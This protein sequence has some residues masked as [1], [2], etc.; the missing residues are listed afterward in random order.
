MLQRAHVAAADNVLV[1][2]ASGGVGTA[3][4]QLAK[5]RGARVT[6]VVH[7]SKM[8]ALAMLGADHVIDRDTDVAAALGTVQMDVVVDNVA[9][10]SFAER[11]KLL[12]NGGRFVTSG[13]IGGSQV[14]M[15]LRPVYLRDLSI[16]GC[17]AWEDA[18][19]SNLI[20]YI[21]LGELRPQVAQ[22]FPLKDIA[23]AQR[24]FLKR[25]HI[26]KFVLIPPSPS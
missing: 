15:D 6:A 14:T 13:A 25:A 1:V 9:G 17:T 23:R 7:R 19:F 26:G 10:P 8:A 4:V 18:V 2:G 12:R 20:S 3:T 21:E 11:L 24:E 5:R 22:V 16:L